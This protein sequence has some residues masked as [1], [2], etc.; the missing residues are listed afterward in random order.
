MNGQMTTLPIFHW[1]SE[2]ATESGQTRFPRFYDSRWFK[3]DL[4]RQR[5]NPRNM[6]IITWRIKTLPDLPLFA[7]IWAS[8][9]PIRDTKSHCWLVDA[10]KCAALAETGD[11]RLP[12]RAKR[13]FVDDCESKRTAIVSNLIYHPPTA[14]ISPPTFWN[15]A[16]GIPWVT[17]EITVHYIIQRSFLY[18]IL[19]P[20]CLFSE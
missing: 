15:P 5:I 9:W 11:A 20:T 6:L 19:R 17:L 4:T 13:L 12:C 1:I 7:R 14:C 3:Q 2:N 16:P 10:R 8:S 18:P